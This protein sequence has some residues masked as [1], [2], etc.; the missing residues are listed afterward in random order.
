MHACY[1]PLKHPSMFVCV[2]VC[3][4]VCHACLCGCRN[5]APA[6]CQKHFYIP[7]RITSICMHACMRP[8]AGA[9]IPHRLPVRSTSIYLSEALLYACMHATL[10][11]CRN[12]TPATYQKHFY[13]ILLA[14]FCT[15]TELLPR[16]SPLIFVFCSRALACL[17]Q[18]FL[19]L[20]SEEDKHFSQGHYDTCSHSHNKATILLSP[21]YLSS[22]I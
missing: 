21:K 6:T 16:P 4:Y 13:I 17:R 9:A 5:S 2:Y 19:L 22:A 7:V 3:M 12:S 18:P 14:V 15:N 8:F 20:L 10:C 11:G 1:A